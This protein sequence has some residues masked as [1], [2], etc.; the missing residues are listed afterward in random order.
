MKFEK[1]NRYLII[2][3]LVIIF[4]ANI[5]YNLVH[6]IKNELKLSW[7]LNPFSFIL[8]LQD[9]HLLFGTVL[10]SCLFMLTIIKL[11]YD[12]ILKRINKNEVPA[13]DGNLEYGSSRWL[14]DKEIKKHF[15]VWN[16]DSISKGGIPVTFLNKKCYY[17][18]SSDHYLVI[19]STGS[20]KSV[21]LAIPL[22]FNLAS[23]GE[24]MVIN[25]TKGELYSYTYQ[26]LKE[27][28][29]NIY[30]LNLR[31]ANSSDGWNPLHLPYQF[32][33]SNNLDEAGDMIENFAKSLT[34]NL[35]S[36]DQYWEKSSNAVLSALCYA[37]MEDATS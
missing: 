11:D 23:A 25:D 31:D 7:T 20:G 17:D 14:K 3:C 4:S 8:A 27:H 32:Y 35:S 24:S 12:F 30:I 22:I 13:S 34:K 26:F 2:L 15:K 36:K 6:I 16:F 1:F 21:S 37:L 19:G 10:L 5:C 9:S 33:K 28:G 29:Y 18:D